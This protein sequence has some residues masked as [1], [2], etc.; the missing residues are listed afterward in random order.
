MDPLIS[1]KIAK[2]QVSGNP[3]DWRVAAVANDALAHAEELVRF[4]LDLYQ[5]TQDQAA[6]LRDLKAKQK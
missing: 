6:E 1:E 4:M 5:I 2:L 3:A